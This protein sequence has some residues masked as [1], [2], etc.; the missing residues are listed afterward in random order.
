MSDALEK[1]KDAVKTEGNRVAFLNLIYKNN[2]EAKNEIDKWHKQNLEPGQRAVTIEEN[3]AFFKGIK[4]ADIEMFKTIT[5]RQVTRNKSD[6]SYCMSFPHHWLTFHDRGYYLDYANNRKRDGMT[7]ALAMLACGYA[8]VLLQVNQGQNEEEAMEAARDVYASFIE[9]GFKDKDI[10]LEVNGKK[11]S[12][13][14]LFASCPSLLQASQ[15]SAEDNERRRKKNQPLSSTINRSADFQ[16]K[17]YA[18]IAKQ[19]EEKEYAK[20]EYQALL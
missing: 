14:E 19:E 15:R 3:K 16:D 7:L 6:G 18:F 9:A 1:I 8:S 5:G 4:A 10:Q 12:S 20:P 2:E 11:V 17:L 13:S